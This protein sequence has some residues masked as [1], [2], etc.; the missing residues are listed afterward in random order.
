[1]DVETK[2]QNSYITCLRWYRWLAAELGF[3]LKF[4]AAGPVLFALRHP[5]SSV[6]LV[7]ILLSLLRVFV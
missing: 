3:K 2:T 6:T 7:C 5:D 1:M 4:P